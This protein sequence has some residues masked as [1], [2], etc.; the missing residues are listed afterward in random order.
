MAEIKKQ[1]QMNRS[2]S[3]S[4]FAKPHLKRT[5][6][7]QKTIVKPASSSTIKLDK[8]AP[9]TTMHQEIATP[10]PAPKPVKF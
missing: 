5:N 7:S 6:S 1:K 10:S 8:K 9:E 3:T 4:G 2:S